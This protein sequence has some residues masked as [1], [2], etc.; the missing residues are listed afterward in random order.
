MK[1]KKK[2]IHI[3]FQSIFGDPKMFE[4]HYSIMFTVIVIIVIISEITRVG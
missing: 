2:I 3:I 1:K 4:I